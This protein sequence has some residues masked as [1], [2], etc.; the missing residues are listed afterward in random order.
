MRK[1]TRSS[2]EIVCTF[3]AEELLGLLSQKYPELGIATVDCLTTQT[4]TGNHKIKAVSVSYI[5]L[6]IPMEVEL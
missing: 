4:S 6:D 3:S 1:L 5:K 2:T